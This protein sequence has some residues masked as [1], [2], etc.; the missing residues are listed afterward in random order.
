M[1]LPINRGTL[2]PAGLL[3]GFAGTATSIGGPPLALLYQ[4]SDR[5]GVRT[6]L[7][8]YFTTG[9]AIS[10]TGLGMRRPAEAQPLLRPL[11]MLALTPSAGGHGRGQRAAWTAVAAVE[12]AA[13]RAGRLRGVGVGAAGA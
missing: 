2:L 5:P 13:R 8:V 9:A 3:S 1:R 6:T 12:G 11:L 10:L 7:A 4:H